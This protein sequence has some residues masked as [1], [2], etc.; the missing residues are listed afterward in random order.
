MSSGKVSVM[1]PVMSLIVDLLALTRPRTPIPAMIAR[2]DRQEP[3]VGHSGR[4]EGDPVVL[5][6]LESPLER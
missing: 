1:L 3:V 4:G 2:E 5:D 6:L